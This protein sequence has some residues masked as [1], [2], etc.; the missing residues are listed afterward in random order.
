M[1]TI[2]SDTTTAAGVAPALSQIA[3]AVLAAIVPALSDN[4]LDGPEAINAVIIGLG[5]IGVWGVPILNVRYG[6]WTK[7]G[8]SV[9]T[10]GLVVLA[11]ALT[12]GVSATEWLQIILAGFGAVGIGVGPVKTARHAA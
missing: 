1:A 4:V 7:V 11:S 5:A 10:A 9:L 12:D 6:R 3:V 8:V 2:K